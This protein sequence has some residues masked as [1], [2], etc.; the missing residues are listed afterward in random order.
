MFIDLEFKKIVL[1][2]FNESFAYVIN[3]LVCKSRS[4]TSEIEA[5]QMNYESFLLNHS[6]EDKVGI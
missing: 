2:L 4:Y 5:I 6:F 3:V 1:I